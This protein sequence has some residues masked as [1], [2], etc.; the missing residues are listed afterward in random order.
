MTQRGNGRVTSRGEVEQQGAGGVRGEDM[1][2]IQ[3]QQRTPA[4]ALRPDKS[5]SRKKA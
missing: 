5:R 3:L 1:G 4:L 2:E